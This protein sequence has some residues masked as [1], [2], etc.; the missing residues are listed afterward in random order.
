M[1]NRKTTGGRRKRPASMGDRQTCTGR[2][3]NSLHRRPMEKKG[4]FGA[5]RSGGLDLGSRGGGE[6]IS[7]KRGNLFIRYAID[8]FEVDS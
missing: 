8:G 5:L 7:R 1:P 2:F 6:M 4:S 3:S